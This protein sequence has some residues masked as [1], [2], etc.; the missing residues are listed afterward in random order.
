ML[1]ILCTAYPHKIDSNIFSLLNKD[2]RSRYVAY[3]TM[4]AE[5]PLR[6]VAA[7]AELQQCIEQFKIAL[8]CQ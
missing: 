4:E 8:D 6:D 7:E 1:G 3:M 2:P 5:H